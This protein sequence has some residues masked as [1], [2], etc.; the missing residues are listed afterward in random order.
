MEQKLIGFLAL[1]AFDNEQLEIAV[2]P[3]LLDAGSAIA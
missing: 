2:A 1:I 3:K